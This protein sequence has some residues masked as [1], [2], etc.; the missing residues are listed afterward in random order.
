M[1]EGG[2][3]SRP[4]ANRFLNIC[5]TDVRFATVSG[6]PRVSEERMA[7]T[8][9]QI[10]DGARRSFAVHGYEAA[11]VRVLERETGLSR[12]AIFHH[13]RDKDALF[14]ELAAEDAEEMAG[15][16]ATSG[17][18]QVMRDLPTRDSGWLG[19]QL[20][21]S[22]RLRTDPAFR[23]AWQ[24]RLG[25]VRAAAVERLERG[26]DSGAVRDDVPVDVLAAFLAL[27][28]DGLVLHL[29]TGMPAA[30]VPAV[31]DLAEQAVRQPARRPR[32]PMDEDSSAPSSAQE[33]SA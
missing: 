26:R 4:P 28:L 19:V 5:K 33:A 31:L 21:V 6:M 32:T 12:G 9:R 14:L 10:L 7:A 3:R 13:F 17:L 29:G 11:T 18:V 27:V 24:Q 8:R 16:V 22:R 25:T 23:T 30:D 15:V 2:R 1:L 20:E